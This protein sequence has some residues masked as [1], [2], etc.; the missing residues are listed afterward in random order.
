MLGMQKETTVT[1]FY[2]SAVEFLMELHLYNIL[3][4][5]PSV[6]PM[7]FVWYYTDPYKIYKI[8]QSLLLHWN[9][10]LIYFLHSNSSPRWLSSYLLSPI[11]E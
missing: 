10:L 9:S 4:T 5:F 1:L 6:S 8:H 7:P 2:V 11:F 3:H